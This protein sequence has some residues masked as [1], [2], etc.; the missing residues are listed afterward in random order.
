MA[1]EAKGAV[2]IQTTSQ[3]EVATAKEKAM[4]E[5]LITVRY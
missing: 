2:A 1:T 5:E 4:L 3:S